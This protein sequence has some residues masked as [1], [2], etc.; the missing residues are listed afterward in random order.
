MQSRL[1]TLLLPPA[2]RT[3]LDARIDSTGILPPNIV[4]AIVE[5]IC[6]NPIARERL[7][8]IAQGVM[9]QL[10]SDKPGWGNWPNDIGEAVYVGLILRIWLREAV[11]A[12]KPG[13]TKQQLDKLEESV[14]GRIVRRKEG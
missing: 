13:L 4:S 12:E 8:D 3:S 11:S 1:S 2:V 6:S 7:H 9:D 10:L 5:R 14:L